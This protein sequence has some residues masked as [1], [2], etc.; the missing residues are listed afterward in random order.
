MIG[1]QS[2]TSISSIHSLLYLENNLVTSKINNF[3][4]IKCFYHFLLQG[5]YGIVYRARDMRSNGYVAL[6]KIRISMSADGIPM[7]TLRE[8]SLLKNLDSYQH[9]NVVK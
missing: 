2:S 4:F 6:K 1:F 8:I 3:M 5:A 9:P 7:T